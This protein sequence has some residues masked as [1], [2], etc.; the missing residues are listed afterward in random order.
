PG[1]GVYTSEVEVGGL[2]WKMLVMKKI[3]SSYLDVY[4]LCR[5]YDASPWSVDVSAEFTFIM[6]GEDR[7]VEREL[8]ETFC[9]RH[10]RWGFAEF[11]PWED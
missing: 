11:T 2:M 1:G 8:K 5:T 4:L 9:H 3:S 10:T 7:H 6:P